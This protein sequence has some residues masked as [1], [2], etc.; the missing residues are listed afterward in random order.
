MNSLVKPLVEKASDECSSVAKDK[1]KFMRGSYE[2]FSADDKVIGKRGAE[3]GVSATMLHFLKIY[4]DDPLKECT[5]RGW[6]NQYNCEI[7]RLKNSGKEVVVRELIDNKRGHAL[8]LGEE[9][10]AQV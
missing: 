5:I 8:L 7:V 6:K 4:P 1:N 9:M 10:D 2:K 3:H